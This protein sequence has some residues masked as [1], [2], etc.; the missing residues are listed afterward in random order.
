MALCAVL[1]ISDVAIFYYVYIVVCVVF[2]FT[3][4]IVEIIESSYFIV[5]LWKLLIALNF[6][7]CCRVNVKSKSQKFL[8]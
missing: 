1:C 6:V 5:F 2:T 8:N 3:F 4:C 7:E